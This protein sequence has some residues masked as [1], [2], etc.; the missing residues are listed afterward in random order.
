MADNVIV[1]KSENWNVFSTL[2]SV[3][4]TPMGGLMLPVPYPVVSPLAP[5]TGTIGTVKAN[6]NTVWGFDETKTPKTQGDEAG[7]GKG[8]KSGTVGKDTWPQEKSSTV[9]AEDK[10]VIRQDD[11]AEMEGKFKDKEEEEKAKRQKCREEQVAAGTQSKD[12]AVREAADRL[13]RNMKA[14]EHAK[15]SDHVYDPTKPVPAGWRN[16]SGDAKALERY[17][18]TSHELSI[19]GTDFRAQLYEPNAAVFGDRYR[20]AVV[21]QGTNGAKSGSDWSNNLR[22]STNFQS[23]YYQRAVAI[24]SITR[25]SGGPAVDFAGHSLGGGLASAASQTSG[26]YAN[27]FNAAGL[28]SRTVP[29]YGRVRGTPGMVNAYRI[30]GDILTGTQEAGWKTFAASALLGPIGIAGRATQTWLTP[31]AIGNRYTLP[32]KGTPLARHDM[33]QVMDGIEGEKKQDQQ[34]IAK[35]TGKEC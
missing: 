23:S 35:D 16:I 15:L 31:D 19:R 27:T 7:T 20:P 24:G 29:R 12:P 14:M 21:F 5:S 9:K 1:R 34:A 10:Q 8:V 6:T 30:D 22:Q 2:P 32:G 3:N 11:K 13:T 33:S 28:H 4:K 26:R 18:L 25:V 17:G